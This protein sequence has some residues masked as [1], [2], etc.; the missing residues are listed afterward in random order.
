PLAAPARLGRSVPGRTRRG[1]AWRRPRVDGAVRRRRW[2]RG[3]RG[4]RLRHLDVAD[5]RAHRAAGGLAAGARG[6]RLLRPADQPLV[7][8]P[9]ALPAVPGWADRLAAAAVAAHARPAGAA[10]VRRLADLVRARRP[11]LVD[12]AR[13]PAAGLPVGPDARRRLLAPAPPDR[14]RAHACADPGHAYVCA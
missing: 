9:A 11:V 8:V 6:A 2:Q 10:L 7:G 13:L 12:A 14:H 5:R 1:D 3:G 4:P